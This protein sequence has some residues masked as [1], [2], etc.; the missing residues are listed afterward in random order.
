[1]VVEWNTSKHQYHFLFTG[2]A[3]VLQLNS[4]SW[5]H[6]FLCVRL[7]GR[8]KTQACLRPTKGNG[9]C[10]I[11]KLSGRAGGFCSIG[12]TRKRHKKQNKMWTNKTKML[13]QKKKH[14]KHR[15]NS[16]KSC[17][18]AN[19]DLN[20]SKKM[21]QKCTLISV[22]KSLRGVGRCDAVKAKAKYDWS[23]LAGGM[24]GVGW[25]CGG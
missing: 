6:F 1:M 20:C 5:L 7:P 3:V 22:Q 25:R 24:G 16:G 19:V 4:Q 8:Q 9:S 2:Y 13:R 15:S 11:H 10:K 17:T 12:A 18:S 23:V 14:E 21:T